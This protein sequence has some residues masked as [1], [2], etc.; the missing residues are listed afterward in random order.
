MAGVLTGCA[1]LEKD[2]IVLSVTSPDGDM[3]AY[4]TKFNPC[5]DDP[6]QKLWLK[7]DRERKPVLLEKLYDD[8]RWCDE[9]KWSPNGQ[10][11]AFLIMQKYLY[12]Y[13]A[14]GPTL[15]RKV[16]L[17]PDSEGYPP[18]P[19][20]T[21][22]SF[23]ADSKTV[24]FTETEYEYVLDTRKNKWNRLNPKLKIREIDI[25]EKVETEKSPT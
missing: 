10:K 7:Q 23:N 15:F 12:I 22:F 18:N 21:D 9:I 3:V 5:I 16:D 14:A 8:Q 2:E 1:L 25:E 6:C 17:V 20:A 11:V 13:E 19:R 24:R 4:V